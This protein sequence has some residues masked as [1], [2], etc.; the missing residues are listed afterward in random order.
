MTE[1]EIEKVLKDAGVDAKD[2]KRLAKTIAAKPAAGGAS[3][4][5]VGAVA[6]AVTAPVISGAEEMFK[7]LGKITF[8]LDKNLN[9][10]Q[11]VTESARLYREELERFTKAGYTR[12]FQDFSSEI[13]EA[14]D[15]SLRL[16]GNLEAAQ[17]A[18]GGLKSDF[19]GFGLVNREFRKGLTQIS[20]KLA[21]AGY[22]MASF[23]RIVDSSV[24]A[25][26]A[27]EGAVDQLSNQLVTLQQNLAIAPQ[28]LTANFEYAQKNFAYSAGKIMENFAKLSK[29]SRQTG[30]DFQKLAGSFGDSLDT[31]EGS[32]QMAGRLNQILG[33]S[34]FNSVEL[35]SMD[36]ATRAKRVREA[37]QARMGGRLENIGKFELKAVASTLNMTPEETRRFLRT[38]KLKAGGQG[39]DKVN[40]QDMTAFSQEKAGQAA[41]QTADAF[42]DLEKSLR[43]FRYPLE[44]LTRVA[45]GRVSS[46]IQAMVPSFLEG[47][48]RGEARQY[49]RYGQDPA[50]GIDFGKRQQ[51]DLDGAMTY[52]STLASAKIVNDLIEKLGVPG[53]GGKGGKGAP[54]TGGGKLKAALDLAL[55]AVGI[56]TATGTLGTALQ[57]GSKERYPDAAT[58]GAS[59][60]DI[61][62]KKQPR[63]N[64]GPQA[65]NVKIGSKLTQINSQGVNM[66]AGS[67]ILDGETTER[68]VREVAS[69]LSKTRQRSAFGSD[70]ELQLN[71]EFAF[72]DF[73]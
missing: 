61:K 47:R 51:I 45:R 11:R 27:S 25:F 71:Q 58:G 63:T 21:A 18:L 68:V 34:V 39:M 31:F 37:L 72:G 38:G 1:A 32:A 53:G 6:G 28:E 73:G 19:K 5:K 54:K 36:E 14:I 65:N 24:F 22:D 48:S 59:G 60:R 64:F 2:A 46:S 50:M 30:L 7:E 56:G 20:V 42:D 44:E 66:K 29:M 49:Q 41:M 8:G 12:Q 55:G 3:K 10:Y 33:D 16:T 15:T 23:G 57:F 26:N 17:L 13:D 67:V 35:L 52:L 40:Q 70:T 4:S 62:P 9:S 43:S 69:K